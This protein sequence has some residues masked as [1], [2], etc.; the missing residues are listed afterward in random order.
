VEGK[1]K[2]TVG[3]PSKLLVYSPPSTRLVL[4]EFR[5]VLFHGVIKAIS[6]TSQ[7]VVI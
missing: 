4:V 6:L 3:L 2:V 1:I 5:K 7:G